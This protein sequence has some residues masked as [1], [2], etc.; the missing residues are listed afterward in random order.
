M[1][2][3]VQT[4]FGS[5]GIICLR[6]KAENTFL[7]GLSHSLFGRNAHVVGKITV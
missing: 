7:M 6:K 2:F 1:A 4:R 5:L 3:G